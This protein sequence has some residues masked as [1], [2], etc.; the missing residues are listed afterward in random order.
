MK[1]VKKNSFYKTTTLKVGSEVI[2]N[3]SDVSL[4]GGSLSDGT[5]D[6]F[7]L[8]GGYKSKYFALSGSVPSTP[9][10]GQSKLEGG[11]LSL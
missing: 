3:F 2:P 4:G 6:Y 7:E 5:Y 10:Y 8:Q 1:A 9:A 11:Y